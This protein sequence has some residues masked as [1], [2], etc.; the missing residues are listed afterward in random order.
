MSRTQAIKKAMRFVNQCA[1]HG[2]AVQVYVHEPVNCYR[3]GFGMVSARPYK[4]GLSHSEGQPLRREW[5]F[6]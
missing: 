6:K 3:D 5:L 2:Y 4:E 1:I